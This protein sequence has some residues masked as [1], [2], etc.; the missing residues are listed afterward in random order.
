MLTSRVLDAGRCVRRRRCPALSA[1]GTLAFLAIAAAHSARAEDAP[2]DPALYSSRYSPPPPLQLP[3]PQ[4]KRDICTA[5]ANP[6]RAVLQ[7]L[8]FG[9]SLGAALM[10]GGLVGFC[11]LRG[12][13]VSL[14]AGR[15]AHV[16]RR[17]A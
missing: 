13:L 6:E 12:V 11:W 9:G 5:I 10:V 17:N 14:W 2:L 3:D 1:A 4:P 8:L 16:T 15:P 7:L